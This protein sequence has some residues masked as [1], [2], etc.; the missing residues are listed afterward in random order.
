MEFE[1]NRVGFLSRETKI[2]LN[3]L[4]RV[5]NDASKCHFYKGRGVNVVLDVKAVSRQLQRL[6]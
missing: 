2:S 5:R 1:M 3:L 6:L 4:Q